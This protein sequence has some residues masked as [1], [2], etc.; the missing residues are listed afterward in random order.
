MATFRDYMSAFLYVLFPYN[1]LA[2]GGVIEQGEET[3]CSICRINFPRTNFHLDKENVLAQKFWGRTKIDYAISYVFFKK[4]NNVQ[5]MLHYLKYKDAPEV[6]KL[7]GNWYGQELLENDFYKN[8]DIIIPVPL[9]PKKL[10]K[11]GYNQS[12]CFGKGLAEVWEI[13]HLEH[14]LKKI[15]NTKSQ[16]KKSRE[17]R[18]NNMKKGFTVSNPEEIRG[19]SILLV[20]DVITTGATLEAC[21]NLLLES[22]AKTVSIATIAATQH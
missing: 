14:G 16:T 9:H 1:C 5:S 7:I 11:R 18:F 8:F 15:T 10:R 6:G 12:A 17:E 19:K 22:D 2:C 13:P 4:Q 20:D 21:A 3:I